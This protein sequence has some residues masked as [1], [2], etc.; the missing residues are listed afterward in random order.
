MNDLASLRFIVVGIGLQGK[1]RVSHAKG[2]VVATVDLYNLDADYR[3]VKDVSPE[4]YDAAFVCTP[5]TEKFS[6]IEYLLKNKK[7]VLVEK[8]LL[9]DDKNQLSAIASLAKKNNLQCYT[10]YNH[11]HEPN[12]VAMKKLIESGELGKIYSCRMF[13]GN[14]TATDVRNSVWRDQRSG[15]IADLGSHLLDS[16]NY[17]F[18]SVKPNMQLAVFNRFENRAPDHAILISRDSQPFVELEMTLCMWRNHFT[19]D[20]LAEN[21]SAHIDSLCKWGPSSFIHRKRNVNGGRPDEVKL[22]LVQSDPTWE[23]EHEHFCS[24]IKN[25]PECTLENDIWINETLAEMGKKL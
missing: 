23:I 24:L 18:G 7:H 1:K 4:K 20:I 6:I 17:F 8:P 12:I 2:S 19:C 14:G 16:C 22:T 3:S 15:V 10:A 21:G 11:R 9:V 5:D 13:Y 25:S